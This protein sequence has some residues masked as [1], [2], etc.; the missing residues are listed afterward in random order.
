MPEQ[1]FDLVADVEKYPEFLPLWYSASILQPP[2][3]NRRDLYYTEQTLQLGPLQKRFRTETLLERPNRIHVTSRDPLFN[4]FSIQWVF[5]PKSEGACLVD[6]SLRCEASSFL[7][8]PVLEV[9]LMEMARTIVRTFERRAHTL[10][11][12][13]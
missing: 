12:G 9:V 11:T 1:I 13:S 2:G 5:T 4:H 3:G 7:L 8:R 6:F 10:Y